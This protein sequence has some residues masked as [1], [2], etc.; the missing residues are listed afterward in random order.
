MTKKKKKVLLIISIAVL[1]LLSAAVSIV[2]SRM[3]SIVERQIEQI[4]NKDNNLSYTVSFDK[5]K[6][7]WFTQSVILKGVT[8]T[9]DTLLVDSNNKNTG[10]SAFY[11]KM[12]AL[13]IRH[14]N[15][16]EAV[17]NKKI[18][19]SEIL[20][21]KPEISFLINKDKNR[22]REEHTKKKK[23][24]H[25]SLDSIALTKINGV[26]LGKIILDKAEITIY[27]DIK[28]NSKPLLSIE[29]L[30]INLSEITVKKLSPESSYYKFDIASYHISGNSHS[31]N[32]PGNKYKLSFKNIT[33]DK[34]DDNITIDH[35]KLKPIENIYKLAAKQ[36]PSKEVY[37]IK[38]DKIALNGIDI[39]DI[40][41]N[42]RIYLNSVNIEGADIL[43]VKD[44]R[45]PENLEKRPLFP[46][47]L[48]YKLNVPLKI[49]TIRLINS[50]LQYSERTKNSKKLMT[51]RL[52]KINSK[53][54][55]VS[56]K[57]APKPLIID[58]NGKL[59]QKV[60]FNI[61]IS[62]PINASGDFTFKGRIGKGNF[63]VFNKATQPVGIIFNGGYL[64]ELHFEGKGNSKYAYGKLV[65]KYQNLKVKI[66]DNSNIKKE[67]GFLSW[68]ANKV[69]RTNNPVKGKL[70]KNTMYFERIPNKGFPGFLWKTI[71]SGLKATL[72]PSFE[73]SNAKAVENLSGKKQ[74]AKGKK[75]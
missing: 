24:Q 9:P 46:N 28:P 34:D 21:Q 2:N 35:L 50:D 1:F 4:L 32:L 10:T 6:L 16:L 37:D 43:I 75:H 38:T 3:K 7:N 59:M 15:V 12:R 60:A 45:M 33:V 11:F 48:L 63:V 39:K 49:D 5:L 29:D 58:F 61:N 25:F 69:L 73:K 47:Q 74:N 44:K 66:V 14:I 23:Q 51:V 17:R 42:G 26:S 27:D 31:I 72:I 19:I 56:T 20:I 67:K 41:S 36:N 52:S 53:I 71:F 65:M 40:I 62:M 64:N 68:A 8:I 55:N 18:E 57:P 54:F 13:R 70:R 30:S 22:Q